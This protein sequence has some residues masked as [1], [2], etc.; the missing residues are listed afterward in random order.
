MYDPD[1]SPWNL[2]LIHR[3]CRAL[4]LSEC[5]ESMLMCLC[6]YRADEK[7][8]ADFALEGGS[9]LHLVLALRGGW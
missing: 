1:P 2:P 3:C 9:T 5:S 8:A 4:Q 6:G 7:T